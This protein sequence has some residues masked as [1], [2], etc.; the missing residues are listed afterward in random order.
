MI[1][2]A[3][4]AVAVVGAWIPVSVA[5]QCG[6]GTIRAGYKSFHSAEYAGRLAIAPN[7]ANSDAAKKS[8]TYCVL[9]SQTASVRN[10]T[11]RLYFVFNNMVTSDASNVET[12]F[13][14]LEASAI[15][16]D[17]RGIFM[18]KQ[19]DSW[20]SRDWER[21]YPRNTIQEQDE[22]AIEIAQIHSGVLVASTGRFG[23]P[24]SWA[25]ASDGEQRFAE[26]YGAQVHGAVRPKQGSDL[27]RTWDMR[28]KLRYVSRVIPTP[29]AEIN[30]VTVVWVSFVQR[31]AKA[32]PLHFNWGTRVAAEVRVDNAESVEVHL[33][34]SNGEIPEQ[35]YRVILE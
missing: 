2:L 3:G 1:K 26:R 6:N 5:A 7:A 19:G 35:Q 11:N 29:N 21:Q 13:I 9:V 24:P 22:R 12:A 16:G 27:I 34:G 33:F 14:G 31:A 18:R 32:R 30:N 15:Q 10:R 4:I 8:Q 20:E 28:H 25:S 17:R 23:A